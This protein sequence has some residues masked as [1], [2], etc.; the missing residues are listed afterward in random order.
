IAYPDDF[1]CCLERDLAA[2]SPFAVAVACN[3]VVI[4]EATH[5]LLRPRIAIS[6]RDADAATIA[7]DDVA[8]AV[9]AHESEV[10]ARHQSPRTD[11]HH[12]P[13]P[14]ALLKVVEHLGDRLGIAPIAVEDVVS[15]RPAIDHDQADQHLR[16]ARLAIPAVTMGTL[17]GWALALEI[18]RRQ[19]VEH[20]VDLQ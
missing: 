11:E 4:A 5:A 17:I 10:V 20:H 2:L 12:A 16:I 18:G 8:M 6:G 19:I 1:R 15:D 13:E 9:F 3:L 7:A 14:E